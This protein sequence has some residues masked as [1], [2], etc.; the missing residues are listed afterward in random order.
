VWFRAY[1]PAS[2]RRSATR[3]RPAASG[4]ERE[5]TGRGW[6]YARKPA[7][8]VRFAVW[9]RSHGIATRVSHSAASPSASPLAGIRACP[10]GA[11]KRGKKEAAALLAP[12]HGARTR[13]REPGELAR[14]CAAQHAGIINECISIRQ[15]FHVA[16]GN[17]RAAGGRASYIARSIKMSSAWQLPRSRR[18]YVPFPSERVEQ[19]LSPA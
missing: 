19:A 10:K 14:S 6:L 7:F 3:E 1:P 9:D 17:A 12:R 18:R 16:P 4:C 2:G 8:R 11:R 5:G 15:F 13:T